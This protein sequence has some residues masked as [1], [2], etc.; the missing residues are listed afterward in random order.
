MNLKLIDE[1]PRYNF[2]RI[3]DD[4]SDAA[5]AHSNAKE[6]QTFYV[7]EG[8]LE[9]EIQSGTAK[10]EQGIDRVVVNEGEGFVL[11]P[12]H[13]YSL[14]SNS[15]VAYCVSSEVDLD[16]PIIEI[17]DDGES[18]KEEP[19]YG[20]KQVIDPKVVSKPWGHELWIVWTKDYHVLKQIGMKAG[21]KSS[22][23]FHREKLETNYL[24]SGIAD[25]IDGY[26][27]DPQ[28]PEEEIR[29]KIK[30]EN[31]NFDDYKNRSHT[32]AHWTSKPGVI[33]RV[34]CVEDYLAYEVSTPELDDVIRL[35]DDSKRQS[36]RINS[37]HI[38]K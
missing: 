38:N 19:L 30:Y 21:N 10:D 2:T 1:T 12:G 3:T 7:H 31:V 34:I 15:C 20:L 16:K 11:T 14:D 35:N 26:Q 25:V 9:L 13:T 28:M 27:L 37:E 5:Y 36:G 17:I 29:A 6:L 8:S 18:R 24:E 23:Q 32:G 33:H 22:L 4:A